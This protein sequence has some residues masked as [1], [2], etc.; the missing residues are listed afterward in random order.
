MLLLVVD[1]AP[2]LF[3]KVKVTFDGTSCD[4]ELRTGIRDLVQFEL[5]INFTTDV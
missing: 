1:E 5:P 2:Y 3:S 4:S